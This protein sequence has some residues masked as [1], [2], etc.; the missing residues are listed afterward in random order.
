MPSNAIVTLLQAQIGILQVH[1]EIEAAVDPDVLD[2][3]YRK[4]RDTV[5][6]GAAELRRWSE[7]PH[8]RKASLDRAPIQRNLELLETPKAKWTAKHIEWANKT[9]A[10]IARM[11]KM[12]KG[13]PVDRETPYSKRDIALMNWGFKP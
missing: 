7:T 12:P 2:T 9:I 3:A 13:T 4:Y 10:F 1:V 6:M 5:N 8:S 11:R